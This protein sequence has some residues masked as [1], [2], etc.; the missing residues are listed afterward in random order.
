MCR[1]TCPGEHPK[2]AEPD[3]A[4]LDKVKRYLR[5]INPALQDDDF[6]AM[7]ASRYRYAQ[8]ICRPTTWKA[9]RPCNCQCRA[10]GW[11]TTSYY[12]PEDRG[13][14]E[15]IGFG[16]RMARDAAQAAAGSRP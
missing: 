5:T 16:R 13:I 3:Q 10:C 15:S 7:R 8:P 11:P 14:S 2:Y 12:Y 1:S 6:L 4:F 9:C